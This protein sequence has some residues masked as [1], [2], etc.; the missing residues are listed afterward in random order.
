[1]QLEVGD[2]RAVGRVFEGDPPW[3]EFGALGEEIE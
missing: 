1:V 2:L 3:T